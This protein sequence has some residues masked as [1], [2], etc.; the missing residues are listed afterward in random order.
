MLVLLVFAAGLGIRLFDL[1]NP[2]LDFHPAR[3]FHSAILARGFYTRISPDLPDFVHDRYLSQGLSEQWIEPPILE[4]LTALTAKL[5][6]SDIFLAARLYSILFW[7]LGG[8]AIFLLGKKL[9]GFAGGL[10]SLMF[11]LFLPY[12][13]TASRSFQPD[14]LM[15]CLAAWS[16][17]AMARL[18][19]GAGWKSVIA[20]GLLAG[21]AILVKQV[22][23]FF[24]LAALLARLVSGQGWRKA[25][26]SR[27]T[28]VVLS[29]A[30]VPALL[31]NLWGLYIDGFLKQQLGGRLY[32]EFWRDITFY[33]RWLMEID[34]TLGLVALI[35]AL[36]G[37]LLVEQKGLRAMLAGYLAG[38]TLYGL[39]FAHHISTHDYYQL[40]LI[41]AAALGISQLAGLLVARISQTQP[42]RWVISIFTALVILGSAFT[43]WRVETQ[44]KRADFRAEPAKWSRLGRE[45]GYENSNVIGLFTDYGASL[46]YWGLT[47]PVVW[48]NTA[49]QE[50]KNRNMDAAKIQDQLSG[51]YFFVV[52]NFADLEKQPRLKQAL[53]KNFAVFEKGDGY[54]V[55]DLRKP[56]P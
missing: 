10:F 52:T 17:W 15:V 13:V 25:F 28:W 54:L 8:L 3:Q 23:V 56:L 53:E 20:A 55:Y 5:T 2:A 22:M 46:M 12:A 38:Y 6:G 16:L 18:E 31:Y 30:L 44:M 39:V 48:P 47:T 49:D 29:L 43:L 19:P 34:G 7:L 36:C 37:I 32:L 40:P 35:A 51:K 4:G 41:P 24:I 21:A 50:L 26:A 14:P 11:F 33:L 9:S 27:K 1:D 42:R 45:M